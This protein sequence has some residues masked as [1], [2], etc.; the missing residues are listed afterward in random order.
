ML[1]RGRRQ[2]A[3]VEDRRLVSGR[4]MAVGG[5]LGALAVVVIVVL[6]GG[7]PR[8]V[9]QNLPVTQS[10]G[11]ESAPPL[12][13]EEQE[14][15][16]FVSVILA[17][18]EDVWNA[19]FAQMGKTYRE[20]KLVLFRDATQTPF[21][22]AEAATGPF[23]SPADEK[24][25]ID[26]AFFQDMQKKLQAPGD[27]AWAYVIAHEVGHHVQNLLGT[28]QQMQAQQQGLSEEEANRLLVRLELQADFLAGLWTHH[29]QR[30]KNLLEAGDIEEGLNAAAAVGDDR[31]QK[32]A[33]GY[34]VPDAFTHGT[35]EQR[36]RWFSL[37]LKTGDLR[38]G[39]TF[40][41]RT[42]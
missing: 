8:Q 2:S 4:Q 3:N 27:F 39:D 36:V 33:Q 25:Y 26:L 15:G 41:A 30:L 40:A 28:M 24:V 17:D 13:A 35:S 10:T 9:L 29:A 31:I 19:M 6:L 38:Q 18:T 23:Y 12:T 1:W 34:V 5:G 42:L 32:R 11:Q 14:L 7:D 16:E 21:G 20:P 37:G 22:T